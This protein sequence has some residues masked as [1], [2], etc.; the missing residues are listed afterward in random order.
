MTQKLPAR[1]RD[2]IGPVTDTRIWDSFETRPG[3][4]ILSTPP[5]CGT[6]WTQ[7][8]LMM[9]IHGQAETG[10]TVWRDS[11][12]LD[13]GMADQRERARQF[14][15]QTHRR[16]I[17]SHSPF[18]S[19]P[20]DPDVIYLTVY[21]HPLDVH[22]SM[23][24][25]VANMKSDILD[26]LFPPEP[27]AAFDRFLNGPATDM[28]TDDLTLS[29]ILQHY[30]SFRSFSH[31]PNVHFF[32]YADL[33][34]DLE[35]QIRRYAAAMGQS[36]SAGLVAGI[37]EAAS[38]GSMKDTTRREAPKDGKSAFKVEHAFFDSATSDKWKGR[39]SKLDLDAYHRRF[40]EL[41]TPEEIIWLE[42]GASGV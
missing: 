31:L 32:H 24:R 34:R 6:T 8:I 41:A 23:E 15:A 35:P 39:L 2:Y 22:F 36:P 29:S 38:F 30:R 17:K 12:W 7:A 33:T 10:R 18:D 16:C 21:R 9:L 14:A 40:A 27:G 4:V 42:A 26:F 25:H 5:K 13:C 37:A 19:L 28:G 11:M 20:F 1:V 3:D